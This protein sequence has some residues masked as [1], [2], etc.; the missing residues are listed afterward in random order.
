MDD[1]F[2]KVVTGFGILDSMHSKNLFSTASNLLEV[3]AVPD[4][5]I[6]L[7]E[8]ARLSSSDSG[9]GCFVPLSLSSRWKMQM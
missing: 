9:P 6:T 5:Q 1:G 8:V 7:Q 2:Y 3:S 4:K